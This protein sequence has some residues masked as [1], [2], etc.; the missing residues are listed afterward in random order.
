MLT[1]PKLKSQVDQLWEKLWTGG[2]A[3]PLDSIERFSYLLFLKRL[4]EQEDAQEKRATMLKK[5]FEPR[6]APKMRWRY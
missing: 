5:T 2:L 6:L 4:D 1:D 3:K